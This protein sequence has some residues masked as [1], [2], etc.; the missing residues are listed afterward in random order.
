MRPATPMPTAHAPTRAIAPE[1][2][3]GKGSNTERSEA[4]RVATER[5]SQTKIQKSFMPA[6]VPRPRESSKKPRAQI[7]PNG[8]AALPASRERVWHNFWLILILSCSAT[9]A[10][11]DARLVE[12]KLPAHFDPFALDAKDQYSTAARMACATSKPANFI[13]YRWR[14]PAVAATLRSMTG[15]SAGKQ[16]YIAFLKSHYGYQINKLNADYGSDAQ[17]FTELLDSPMKT[18]VPAQ[19]AEFDRPVRREMYAEVLAALERCDPLHA[20]GGVRFL[21]RSALDY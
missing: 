19:D 10:A 1:E 21:V 8:T 14:L 7:A 9:C 13:G 6:S 17:S 20:A 3:S 12:L 11:Q 4:L 2:G 16:I 15:D 5:V 18:G